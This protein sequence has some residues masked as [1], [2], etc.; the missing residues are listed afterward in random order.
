MQRKRDSGKRKKLRIGERGS[1]NRGDI[2]GKRIE[3][4]V[5]RLGHQERDYDKSREIIARE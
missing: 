3:T 2:I 4:C 1:G 5:R